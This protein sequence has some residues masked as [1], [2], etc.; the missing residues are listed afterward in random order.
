MYWRGWWIGCHSTK[1]FT[2]L[3]SMGRNLFLSFNFEKLLNTVSFFYL[4]WFKF[5]AGHHAEFNYGHLHKLFICSHPLYTE[6]SC[7]QLNC[8]LLFVDNFW[9]ICFFV[10]CRFSDSLTMLYLLY[11]HTLTKFSTQIGP[12]ISAS[13]DAK[14]GH[15][16]IV[17]FITVSLHMVDRQTEYITRVDYTLEFNWML[18]NF[19]FFNEL[20]FRMKIAYFDW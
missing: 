13:L 3:K 17:I 18:L 5:F 6:I 20:N 9:C 7:W 2:V 11:T 1:I 12:S 19:F 16:L 15:I 14:V 4:F 10:W 8:W